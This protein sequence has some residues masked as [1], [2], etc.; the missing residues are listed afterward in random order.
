MKE[1]RGLEACFT[2]FHSELAL[3]TELVDSMV[4]VGGLRRGYVDVGERV[5]CA[6]GYIQQLKALLATSGGFCWWV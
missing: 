1:T 3:F 6:V 2:V 4:T 5:I